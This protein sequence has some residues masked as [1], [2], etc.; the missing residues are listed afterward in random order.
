[1]KDEEIKKLIFDIETIGED[2]NKLDKT[3]Q[4][5]LISSI[6]KI[7]D[8]KEY[9]RELES[10]KSELGLSPLTGEIVAIGTLDENKNKGAVYFQDPENQLSETE[11]GGI[12]FKPMSEKEM[13]EKFW[14][15]AEKCDEF[16][17]FNGHSFDIPFLM[18]RS[19][20][21]KIKPTK[22]LMKGR[23]LYQQNNNAKNID[24]FEQLTFYG[25]IDKKRKKF[26]TWCRA[27]GIES[28]KD[29]GISGNDIGKLFKE[30]RYLDIAKYNAGDLIATKKLFEYWDKYLR[31]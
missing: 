29:Q 8:S 12:K 23:Y 5:V 25:S 3:T 30:K 15:I 16:I 21:Y 22:N 10:L 18:I 17:S 4:E 13:L 11:E 28:P 19:A 9:E 1:M 20:I 27:F 14:K 7:P 24:L 26:H 6:K 31:F 2:F